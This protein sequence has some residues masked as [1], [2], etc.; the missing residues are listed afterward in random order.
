M[1]VK[2]IFLNALPLGFMLGFAPSIWAT[3]FIYNF[4]NPTGTLGVSQT[5]TDNGVTLTAYGYNQG[6]GTKLFGKNDGGDE[7][8]LG[9]FGTSDHEITSNGFV[10]LDML[11]LWLLTPTSI[12][13]SIGSVQDDE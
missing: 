4:D 2:T 9:L 6:I 8:G 10:Q 3:P 7:N 11:N 13:L 5:Y 12:S 1:Q